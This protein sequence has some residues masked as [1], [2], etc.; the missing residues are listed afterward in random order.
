MDRKRVS[1]ELRRIVANDPDIKAE[2]IKPSATSDGVVVMRNFG[3]SD[4]K[5]MERAGLKPGVVGADGRHRVGVYTR[6]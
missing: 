2:R 4:R 1:P 5:A 6:V 3:P